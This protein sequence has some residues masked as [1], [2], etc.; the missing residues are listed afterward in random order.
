MRS[1]NRERS[2]RLHQSTLRLHLVMLGLEVSEKIGKYQS[3]KESLI[4]ERNWTSKGRLLI[5]SWTTHQQD[6]DDSFLIDFFINIPS[7]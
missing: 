1:I 4:L 2:E 7:H 6:F 5:N 3:C